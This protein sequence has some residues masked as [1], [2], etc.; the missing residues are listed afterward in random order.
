MPMQLHTQHTQQHLH[1]V[2][3]WLMQSVPPSPLHSQ[4][5]VQQ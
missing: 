4:N 1:S 2:L 5:N 3:G